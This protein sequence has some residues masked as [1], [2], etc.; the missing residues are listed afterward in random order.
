MVSFHLRIK[1]PEEK[2]QL[3]QLRSCACPRRSGV[4]NESVCRGSLQGQLWL[5][6]CEGRHLGFLSTLPTKNAKWSQDPLLTLSN[7][8]GPQRALVYVDIL[9]ELTTDKK[10][11]RLFKYRNK[12]PI[13]YEHKWYVLKMKMIVFSETRNLSEK[14][15]VVLYFC[16]FLFIWLNRRQLD[17]H[18]CFCIH[19]VVIFYF[20]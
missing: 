14:T 19:F 9:L 1:T 17:S 5:P 15:G 2:V 4:V 16:K 11:I 20:G 7:Y 10:I 3:A 13:S 12:K 18:I 6:K 8:W